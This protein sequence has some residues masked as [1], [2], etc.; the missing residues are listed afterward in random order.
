VTKK[1]LPTPISK[2]KKLSKKQLIKKVDDWIE[3]RK[4]KHYHAVLA[5]SEAG[6]ITL[7]WTHR[8]NPKDLIETVWSF[9]SYHKRMK[10]VKSDEAKRAIVVVR[11]DGRTTVFD[12]IPGTRKLTE[13]ML[14]LIGFIP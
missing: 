1:K 8:D 5:C 9:A 11:S 14:A 12:V 13:Q 4:H 10:K 3:E 2:M 7:M 6:D